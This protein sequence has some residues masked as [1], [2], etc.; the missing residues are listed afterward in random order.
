[1]TGEGVDVFIIDT[2]LDIEHPD[3]GGRA[4]HGYDFV[5]NDAES[6]DVDGHGT[7]CAGIVGSDTY[8]VA[9]GVRL[10][11]VR[12]L[13]DDGAGFASDILMG[14]DWVVANRDPSRPAIASMSLGGAYNQAENDAVTAAHDNGVLVL[15]AAGKSLFFLL[16]SSFLLL[17]LSVSLSINFLSLSLSLS[18]SPPPLRHHLHP[19]LSLP[20]P[21][22]PRE[23]RC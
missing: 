20:L 16:P 12:V 11:G 10:Y 23:R 5:E 1:M 2:G 15:A 14:I 17:S 4:F 9:P 18:L 6:W 19:S 8:G 21:C 13:G 3:F 22:S 7:H